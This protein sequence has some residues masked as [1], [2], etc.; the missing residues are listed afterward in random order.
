MDDAILVFRLP[1]PEEYNDLRRTAGW[2]LCNPDA[3]ATA[4]TNS[5]FAVCVEK[6]GKF[7]GSGRIVGDGA[8]VYMIQDVIIF[9]EHQRKGYGT[10]I[11]DALMDYV[12]ENAAQNAHISLFAAKGLEGVYTRYGFVERPYEQLGPGMAFFKS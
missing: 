1:T 3:V 9:P 12:Q 8:L 2:G 4:L 10:M 11:M 7:L 6:G 5:I